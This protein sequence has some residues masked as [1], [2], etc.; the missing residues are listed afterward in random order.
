MA[1]T[2]NKP[3]PG[4]KTGSSRKRQN[5]HEGFLTH[6]RMYWAKLSGALAL[7]LILLYI[8][9]PLPGTHF[10]SSW[11]GYT[12]GTIGAL[13]ILWLTMLGMRKRAITPG[14]WSLKAWTSAHVYLGLLVTVV[15]TLHSGF[16]FGWNV[17]TLAWAL[18]LLVVG[19][20]IFGIYAYATLP[21]ALSANRYDEEGAITEKQM[22]EALRSLDRQIHDAA[23]PLDAQAAVLVGQSLEQDPFGGSFWNRVTGNYPNCATRH[24]INEL[25]A[26]RASRQ[27]TK[28]DLLGKIDAQLT[29]KE[30]MLERLR[31]HLKLKSWLQAWLY[32]HVPVTFAL[33]AALSAHVVSVFFYW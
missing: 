1:S 30:S 12:L 23:Q 33:I 27:R 31:Q 22:I 32:I 17:H 20:G 29:R 26:I 9:V 25:R 4:K 16:Y 8:F 18:M 14:R 11:L 2:A 3:A 19:S 24:A 5:T 15:G 28:E 21:R 6:N 10:G 13:L 7:A